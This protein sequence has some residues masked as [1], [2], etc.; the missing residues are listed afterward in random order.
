MGGRVQHDLAPTDGGRGGG[1]VWGHGRGIDL[2]GRVAV[3][4]H[5]RVVVEGDLGPARAQRARWLV[6]AVAGERSRVACRGDTDPGPR[7]RVVAQVLPRG[8]WG[9]RLLGKRPAVV[10]AVEVQ[11][12]AVP[13]LQCVPTS[14]M[15]VS[16][17]CTSA[18]AAAP[19]ASLPAT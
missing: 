2:K 4:E 10:A 12:S 6:P 7:Q 13:V 9:R 19:I 14:R 11:P 8:G 1:V 18:A 15:T 17:D 16:P 5:R 3:V